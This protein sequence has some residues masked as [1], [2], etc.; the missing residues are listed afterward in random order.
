MGIDWRL[1]VF[2]AAFIYAVALG[3]RQALGLFLPPMVE[4][5]V[6]FYSFVALSLA[7]AVQSLLWGAVSPVF[8]A[9]ADRFGSP[10]VLLVGALCYALGL[11]V[12]TLSDSLLFLYGG[13]GVLMGVGVGATSISVIFAAIIKVAPPE[14]RGLALGLVGAGGSLGQFM[15]APFTQELIAG[16][17]WQPA[18]LVL[19]VVAMT[20]GAA[21]FLLGMPKRAPAT[22]TNSR[23]IGARQ[24]DSR[25][26]K[27]HRTK[28]W[29]STPASAL[30]TVE[31]WRRRR[32]LL[33]TAFSHRGFLL[34]NAGFF[35][36]GF[37]VSFITTHL[38][39]Q[40][41]ALEFSA[42]LAAWA[43]ALIGLFNMI[44][45][46]VAGP[47]SQRY[48]PRNALAVLYFARALIV[49]SWLV[50]PK[51]PGFALVFASLVGL[52]WLATVPLTSA[53]VAR[54]FGTEWLATLFGVTIFSHQVGAFVGAWMGGLVF[55]YTESF[56]LVWMTAA[57]LALV[58]A[59]IHLPI[60][61]RASARFAALVQ[62]PRQ[63]PQSAL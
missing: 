32:A 60:D 51:T 26:T 35:T 48:R 6:L 1:A 19:A 47:A 54:I 36:C 57:L 8:G 3:V 20:M 49:L 24:T 16:L 5:A 62:A 31:K 40:F 55:E 18:M 42:E 41:K 11:V 17:G 23:Q 59:L 50:A 43:L 37:H 27:A 2:A 21:G 22:E 30:F 44:G 13:L 34:L 61:D 56:D 7:I 46:F 9:L 53:T 25:Q 45:S 29:S 52:T 4:D 28:T 33:A 39:T 38:P 12:T 15:L 58:S 10:V 63:S 14:R